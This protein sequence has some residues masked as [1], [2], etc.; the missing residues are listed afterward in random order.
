MNA[1]SI[2]VYNVD[3]DTSKTITQP[4]AHDRKNNLTP[5]T[6]ATATEAARRRWEKYR[7]NAAEA[8][9]AEAKSILPHVTSPGHA[10]GALN[11]RLY[12]QIMDSEKPRGDD[13]EVL[14]RNI[15][16]I[17]RAQDYAAAA[18]NVTNILTISDTAAAALA[19]ALAR[20]QPPTLDAH[21]DTA[22][23]TIEIE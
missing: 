2:L 14:G 7:R 19:A 10:W 8:V 5:F 12:Q 3:M 15:G 11:A 16:A 21:A 18:G 6:S 13:V 9:L 17:P 22:E 20:I 4:R 1:C 23:E